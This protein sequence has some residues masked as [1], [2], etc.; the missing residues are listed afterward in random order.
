MGYTTEFVGEV[1]IVPPLNQE[2]I[3][4][5]NKFSTT[6]RMKRKNGPYFVDGS[7]FAEQGNDADVEEYNSPPD[8]Q[9][10]LWCQW[11]P[12]DGGNTIE[13]DGG[14]KFYH[15]AEWM[16]YII[17]HFLK[18]GAVAASELPFLQ[19]NHVCNG[20]IEAQ[21]D[22]RD[23]RWLL[24]VINNVVTTHDGTIHYNE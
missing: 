10:G 16:E 17:D 12:T 18:P 22:D 8:G 9:P 19:A 24:K 4:F 13:W 6:R 3:D 7:G 14:E 1:D 15:A 11:V 21:G 2:E 5:L 20:R 23:D